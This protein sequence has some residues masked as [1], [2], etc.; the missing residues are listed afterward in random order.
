MMLATTTCLIAAPARAE[1]LE[2]ATVPR[3][4]VDTATL[5]RDTITFSGGVGYL[6]SYEGSNNYIA[7]PVAVV[8]G[9]VMGF[10]FS[11]NGLQLS[12]DGVRNRK[13]SRLDVMFGPIIG[14]NVNRNARIVD[15]Q[16]RALGKLNSALQFGGFVGIGKTGVLTSAY[17]KIALRV[18]YLRDISGVHNSYI[19]SPSIE[20]GM[21]ISR[22][23][24]RRWLCG[25]L[26]R[27]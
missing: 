26:F 27:C 22:R 2:L 16:V 11:T 7:V 14:L 6:P 8:R 9:R 19:I 4:E 12:V 20:Y 25:N 13:G 18:S 21:P 3:I 15:P 23:I 1:Q 10:N 17:D 5:N 24:R